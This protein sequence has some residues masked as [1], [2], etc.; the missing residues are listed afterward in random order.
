MSNSKETPKERQSLPE[1]EPVNEDNIIPVVQEFLTV[2]KKVVETGKINIHKSLEKET[3]T[4][5]L[6]LKSEEYEIKRVAVKNRLL[7][8]RPGS[9][10]KDGNIIIPV[11]REVAQ[12]VIKYE[13][14]EEIHLLRRETEKIHEREITLM[15]EKV[16]IDR[17][18]ST[19]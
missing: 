9:F 6:P 13:V 4:I 8:Q 18:G 12:V 17:E 16:T 10:E 1:N 7:D 5:K 11:V 14:T 19:K 2:D 3:E 15:K